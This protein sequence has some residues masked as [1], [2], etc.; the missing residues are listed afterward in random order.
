MDAA[1]VNFRFLDPSEGPVLTA[2]IE[3]AYGQS[4][5]VRWVYGPAEVEARL[6]DGRYYACVAE[7]AGGELLCHEGMAV[8]EAGDR[9]A[10]SGQAVTMPQARGQHIF[11]RTKRF[12]MDWAQAQGF[13][14]KIGRAHV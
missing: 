7:S 1:E 3:A 12:L 11:T 5:D 8:V 4:Y 14:G 9:V 2:A 6:A 10:H 13:A